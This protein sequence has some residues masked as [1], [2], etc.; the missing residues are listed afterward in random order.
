MSS[1]E[2]MEVKITIEYETYERKDVKEKLYEFLKG[3]DVV[4]LEME[5]K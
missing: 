5:E 2:E 3:L 4:K 1:K